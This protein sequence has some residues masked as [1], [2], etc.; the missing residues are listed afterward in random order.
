MEEDSDDFADFSQ[1]ETTD[2]VTSQTTEEQSATEFEDFDD[3]ESFQDHSS[4]LPSSATTGETTV[5]TSTATTHFNQTTQDVI[6][7][8]IKVAF[9]TLS[10]LCN[11]SCPG[12]Y[13]NNFVDVDQVLNHPSTIPIFKDILS[14]NP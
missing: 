14:D 10:T 7:T 4:S 9:P 11:S 3:F 1:A 6:K 8:K 12:D 2:V 13:I 5:L